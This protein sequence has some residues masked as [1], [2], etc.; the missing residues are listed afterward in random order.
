LDKRV[1]AR[2][3]LITKAHAIAK[4]VKTEGLSDAAIRTAVVVAKLG[5]AAVA[6]KSDAYIDARFDMLVEDASKNG[7][8]PFRTVVQQGLSQ[9]NDADKVVVD[10]YSQMVADMK[11]GKTSAATN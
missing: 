2:A 11:A 7:A 5:D 4:D 3:D 8:D 10:A 6:N 1:Q 9:A